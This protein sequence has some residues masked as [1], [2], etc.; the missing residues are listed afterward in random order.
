[1]SRLAILLS[2]G[3]VLT[4]VAITAAAAE[5]ASGS[6]QH[7]FNLEPV[8]IDSQDAAGSSIGLQFEISGDLLAEPEPK[9]PPGEPTDV[10][11]APE[12]VLIKRYDV[13]YEAKGV[14]TADSERNPLN[15]IDAIVD[16]RILWNAPAGTFIGGAFLRYETD[17]SMDNRQSEYGLRGTY[18]RLNTLAANDTLAIDVK[19]GEVD[20]QEDELRQAALGTTSL[21]KFNRWDAEFLYM[22]PLSSDGAVRDFEFNYR[23][24]LEDDPPLAIEAADLD[25]HRLATFRLGLKGGFFV[26][27]SRGELPFDRESDRIYAIGF[28]YELY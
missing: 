9:P 17:Q 23:Y 16:G 3:S 14:A 10:F 12:E 24:Y 1:M 20:P 22:A 6:K 4:T 28:T 27:Y 18:T 7:S 26:A 13:H 2:L 5:Q 21:E 15:Y 11:E 8:I 19:F 25:T